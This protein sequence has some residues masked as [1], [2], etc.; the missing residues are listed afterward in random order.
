MLPNCSVYN[1]ILHYLL[2]PPPP[3]LPYVCFVT[4]Y[5]LQSEFKKNFPLTIPSEISNKKN[6]ENKIKRVKEYSFYLLI[7]STTLHPLQASA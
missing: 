4:K 6:V 7:F 3:L 5:T 2:P 1:N